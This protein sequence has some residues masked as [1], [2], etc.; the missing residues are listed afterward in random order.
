MNNEPT[1]EKWKSMPDLIEYLDMSRDSIL[2]AITKRG[3]PAHK[4]GRVWKFKFSE[5]DEWIR[6]GQAAGDGENESENQDEGR[7]KT[8]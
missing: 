3:M 8:K 1:L 4:V 5:V 6:S 2:E 7:H